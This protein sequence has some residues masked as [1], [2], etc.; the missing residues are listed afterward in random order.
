M[1]HSSAALTPVNFG[2]FRV[3]AR[4]PREIER[5]RRAPPQPPAV[6]RDEAGNAL[7]LR[8]GN[9]R[10]TPPRDG[11]RMRLRPAPP[12]PRL[13]SPRR[14]MLSGNSGGN[15]IEEICGRGRRHGL[16]GTRLPAATA[17]DVL[18]TH[19][20]DPGRDAPAW[21]ATQTALSN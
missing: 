11:L 7:C 2:Y 15:T 3:V 13:P 4:S 14:A 6:E 16:S 21:F 5:R 20:Q 19:R 17:R 12:M 18:N 10:R 1:E 8:C 9:P